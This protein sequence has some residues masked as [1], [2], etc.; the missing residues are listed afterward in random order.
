VQ[1]ERFLLQR[2]LANLLHNAVE[3]SPRGGEIEVRAAIEGRHCRVTVRD[4][5]PGIPD[6]ALD[7]VFEKFYSLRRPESGRKGTGLGLSFVKE[8]AALHRG[9]VQLANHP[10][11]GALATL[12]LDS[13]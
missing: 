5:G 10:D 8:I 3:F 9:S 4:H 11:G 6:Y 7:R 1:G 2:A 12:T 13:A